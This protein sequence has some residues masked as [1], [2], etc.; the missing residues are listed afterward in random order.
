MRAAGIADLRGVAGTGGTKV[1][2]ADRDVDPTRRRV[3]WVLPR[4]FPEF[5]RLDALSRFCCLAVEAMGVAL[6]KST[7][8]L[9][10]TTKGCLHADVLFQESLQHEI[11]PGLFP[12]TLPSTCLGEIAIRHRVTGPNLCL[13]TAPNRQRSALDEARLLLELGEADA[14]VV[15]MGDVVPP[16]MSILAVHVARGDDLWCPTPEEVWALA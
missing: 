2:W 15:C 5:R 14:A 13:T 3:P 8:L 10:S 7:A 16:E 9:L 6:P 1:L 4:P 12:Y 11:K